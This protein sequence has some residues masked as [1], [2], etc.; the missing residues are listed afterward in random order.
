MYEVRF[1][2]L[3]KKS[4]KK[5]GRSGSFNKKDFEVFLERLL[6][7]DVLPRIYKDHQLKGSL[8]DFREC[9]I[10]FDL[11]VV[12][13]KDTTLQ[14]IVIANIGTHDELFT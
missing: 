2:R 8:S 7:G 9:H 5:L 12:Y 6:R 1:S 4:L 10:G 11:L 13:E 14:L 3:A